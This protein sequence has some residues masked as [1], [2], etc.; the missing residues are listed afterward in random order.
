MRGRYLTCLLGVLI[1]VALL[2]A[3]IAL[4]QG[5]GPQSTDA[6]VD[7][8][9]TYQ[10]RLMD[11][12]NPAD[13]EYDFRFTLYDAASDGSQVGSPVTLNDVQVTDG[14]F[15][16]ELDFGDVF[17]GTALWLEV[18]VRP[19]DSTGSYT[20][21][22]PRQP[23]TAAP[24]ALSLR[25]GATISSTIANGA[26]LRMVNSASGISLGSLTA[27]AWGDSRDGVGVYGTSY[28]SYGVGGTSYSGAGVY[29]FSTTGYGVIAAGGTGDLKL[30]GGTIHS[31]ANVWLHLDE[32]NNSSNAQFQVLDGANTAVFT[33]TETGAVSWAPQTAR[34]VVPAAAFTPQEDGYVYTNYG[35]RLIPGDNNSGDYYAPVY[36]PQ[37]AIVTRMIFYWYDTSTDNEGMAS[38]R[39]APLTTG[40]PT[41]TMA[42]VY[43]N[44]SSGYG[45][46]ETTTINYS[47]VDNTTFMYYLIWSLR[48]LDIAGLAVV[49][50]YTHTGPH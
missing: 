14:Y 27:G 44:G 2:T 40:T 41:Y 20:P 34:I 24:Y 23:L 42:Q 49:I 4:A 37:G 13:G 45:S 18:E 9:F 5:P 26:A 35:S 36:L 19:G 22:S 25:P 10:G 38:L 28:S 30:I 31:D 32:D 21:L 8:G 29:G 6:S 12:D 17:D 50:E 48:D 43:S 33:V 3:G 46:S 7:T 1:P 16:V 47:A 11:G 39:R 15:T